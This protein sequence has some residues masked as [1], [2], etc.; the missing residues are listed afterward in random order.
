MPIYDIA[1][2]EAAMAGII[3]DNVSADTWMWLQQFRKLPN[4]Y[5]ALNTAFMII[6][7]KTGKSAVTTN[8]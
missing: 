3:K 8:D 1:K 6:P 7:R 5:S 2:I 4:D